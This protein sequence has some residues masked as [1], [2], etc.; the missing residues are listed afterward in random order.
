MNTDQSTAVRTVLYIEDNALNV[1][2]VEHVIAQRPSVTLLVAM[3]GRLGLELATTY[4]PDLILLDL[5]LPD[6]SGEIVL[7]CLRADPRTSPIPVIMVTG[8]S[9]EARARQLLAL[10]ADDC[11][12]KP[13]DIRR[14]LAIIDSLANSG[15][16]CDSAR[17]V[18]SSPPEGGCRSQP[19]LRAER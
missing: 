8:D 16:V 4:R 9:S 1:R 14:L 17:T 6:L 10:G 13:F 15:Y 3:Q 11:L 18:R 2:L 19:V 5:Q 12:S 7:A